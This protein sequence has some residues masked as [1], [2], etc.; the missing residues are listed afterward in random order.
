MVPIGDSV[1]LLYL[2]TWMIPFHVPFC[3]NRETEYLNVAVHADQKSGNGSFYRQCQA[4][5]NQEFGFKNTVFTSSCTDALEL[6]ALL[7]DI[8]P[9]DEVIL[10]SYTFVS[11]ANAFLLRGASIVFCDSLS[12][13][14]NLDVGALEKLISPRTKAIVVVH[15]GGRACDMNEILKLSN[16]YGFYVVEDAAQCIGS[17]I[18]KEMSPHSAG[19]NNG[20]AYLGTQGHLATFSF[21]DT[22]NIHCGEGGMLLI[23]DAQFVE[24]AEILKDKGTNRA[25]FFR[26]EIDKYTW[27]DLGS[28]Y[29]PS[30]YNMAVLL[31]QLEQWNEVTQ[32]RKNIWQLY[33]NHFSSFSHLLPPKIPGNG[34]NFYLVFPNEMSRNEFSTSMRTMGIQTLFHYQPLHRSPLAQ[35]LGPQVDLPHADKF[36]NGLVRL[37]LY[38]QLSDSE[39]MCIAESSLKC[40]MQM[41]NSHSTN[42]SI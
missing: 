31:A 33:H 11:T 22:K 16:Q 39:A 32:R 1:L 25:K 37:P 10:P 30:E 24:R 42:F 34:H 27:V 15:Y 35:A 4:T 3:A 20:T 7:L 12:D 9:G 2:A 18:S 29:L 26:G 13:E 5:V 19:N 41:H 23:N 40:V 8:R 14:P 6:A 38:P 28:S 36:G 17:T 21:H